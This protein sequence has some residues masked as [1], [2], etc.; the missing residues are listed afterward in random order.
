[1]YVG[2][3]V[4]PTLA[5]HRNRLKTLKHKS[6]IGQTWFWPKL[7]IADPLSLRGLGTALNMTAREL[8]TCTIEGPGLQKHHQNC[9]RR[10]TRKREKERKC[11]ISCPPFGAHWLHRTGPDLDRPDT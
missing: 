5:K 7:A 4:I 8:Q 11:E 2:V 10:P 3:R 1:M 9:M 6:G